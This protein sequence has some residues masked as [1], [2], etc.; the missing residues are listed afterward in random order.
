MF[1]W[2][3]LRK[4]EKVLIF[5]LWLEAFWSSFALL[6]KSSMPFG[7]F[8]EREGRKVFALE[9]EPPLVLNFYFTLSPCMQSQYMLKVHFMIKGNSNWSLVSFCSL[10]IV[11]IIFCLKYFLFYLLT[12]DVHHWLVFVQRYP[13]KPH[14]KRGKSLLSLATMT[15]TI[16]LE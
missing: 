16:L 4:G 12:D 1:H 7:P 15:Q 13:K 2:G 3:V 5:Y 9:L 11:I 6:D 10:F 14:A 8:T